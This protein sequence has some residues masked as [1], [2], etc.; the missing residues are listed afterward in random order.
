MAIIPAAPYKF[1][2]H[3]LEL[4]IPQNERIK[5]AVQVA[6]TLL[7]LATLSSSTALPL[8]CAVSGWN[9]LCSVASGNPFT[10]KG[11]R[12]MIEFTCT[13]FRLREALILHHVLNVAENSCTV[14]GDL[15]QS[16]YTDVT[17]KSLQIIGDLF[18][19]L[20]LIDKNSTTLPVYA[21]RFQA[22]RYFVQATVEHFTSTSNTKMLD[23]FVKLIMASARLAQA[24]EASN[25]IQIREGK[26]FV[27]M[28]VAQHNK[29]T[30]CLTPEGEQQA[31]RAGEK[32]EDLADGLADVDSI[33][34]VHSGA[35][36]AQQTA[37]KIIDWLEDE[38][39]D[40][41]QTYDDVDITVDTRLQENQNHRLLKSLKKTDPAAYES[42]RKLTPRERFDAKP[43]EGYETD[44]ENFNNTNA[45]IREK[46]DK[47]AKTTMTVFITHQ[48][49][50]INWLRGLVF[51][52]ASTD[53]QIP[54]DSRTHHPTSGE[55][56]PMREVRGT[57]SQD[58]LRER[59]S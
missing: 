27:V 4:I 54:E 59:P 9:V 12:N 46:L 24:H 57:I 52:N 11:I 17:N 44:R 7:P 13:F 40:E 37:E 10:W 35:P 21:L 41:G 50:M 36:S 8:S 30:G 14:M 34:I 18:Y 53:D 22:V 43:V 20:T 48:P 42:H 51:T 16:R 32:I 55:I 45:A 23:V 1:F 56:Y 39:N 38:Y 6:E 3:G 33:E 29:K 49:N 28:R 2:Q 5:D 31:L 15:Q 25:P 19:L 58:G 47:T 26:P